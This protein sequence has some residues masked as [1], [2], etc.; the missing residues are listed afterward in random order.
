MAVTCTPASGSLF[1]VGDTVVNCAAS[2]AAGN[3]ATGAFTVTVTPYVP[4][5]VAITAGGDHT[6][7]LLGD[8]T[9]RCWGWNVSR[10]A[11]Q[12]HHHQTRTPR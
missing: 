11:R 5:A 12:R 3:T 1:A 4:G 8:G 6:C 7:A 2:D 9:A 10:P